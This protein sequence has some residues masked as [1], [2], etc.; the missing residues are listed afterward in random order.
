MN[1]KNAGMNMIVN[2]LE[3]CLA[4]FLILE[5]NSIY[6]AVLYSQFA[7][8]TRDVIIVITILLILLLSFMNRSR[9]NIDRLVSDTIIFAFLLVFVGAFYFINVR[10]L[11]SEPYYISAFLI[12]VPLIY[13][14]LKQIS[15]SGR[16]FSLFYCIS[17]IVFIIAIISLILW[18]S[19]SVFSIIRPSDSFVMSWAA[20]RSVSNYFNLF[21]TTS[22][23]MEHIG[24]LNIDLYRNVGIF[25]ESPM[26]NV[27]LIFSLFTELFLRVHTSKSKIA[28]LCMTI[29]STFGTIGIAIM[30]IG[31]VIKQLARL[32]KI[33]KKY[34]PLLIGGVLLLCIAGIVF[35]V[36]NKK[37]YGQSS[38]NTRL[39][40]YVAGYQTWLTAPFFGTGFYDT[41][42]IQKFMSEFRS[43][44]LGFS[45]SVVEVLANGGIYL[46]SF[47]MIP[48]I[49]FVM[50]VMKKGKRIFF[51]SIGIFLL[52]V[53]TIFEYHYLMLMVVAYGYSLIRL[54]IKLKG[55]HKHHW[56]KSSKDR[57]TDNNTVVYRKMFLIMTLISLLAT[58][59]AQLSIAACKVMGQRIGLKEIV[60]LGVAF[61]PYIFWGIVT[62]IRQRSE[63]KD[64]KLTNAFKITCIVCSIIQMVYIMANGFLLF[65]YSINNM[66]G[67]QIQDDYLQFV[68]AVIALIVLVIFLKDNHRCWGNLRGVKTGLCSFIVLCIL[69]ITCALWMRMQIKDDKDN[70]AAGL[71]M[72]KA[73]NI[74]K[75]DSV[76]VDDVPYIYQSLDKNAVYVYGT[77][78]REEEKNVIML[79]NEKPYQPVVD[80]YYK[81]YEYKDKHYMYFKGESYEEKFQDLGIAY[82]DHYDGE[83]NLKLE[84]IIEFNRQLTLDKEGVHLN[85]KGDSINY[86]PYISWYG[87]PLQVDL[88]L[89]LE[90]SPGNDQPIA[91][92]VLAYSKRQI[93][94]AQKNLYASDFDAEG[95]ATVS[96]S[97]F[98]K[99]TNDMEVLV[100]AEDGTKMNL[101]GI[102]YRRIE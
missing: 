82:L 70:I 81:C 24:F 68:I 18:M 73:L 57:K 69:N 16:P 102:C 86:G 54:P 55:G 89:K 100:V 90:E 99:W 50:K 2:I 20:K 30:L 91:H 28:L 52:F 63:Q 26:F 61:I 23:Q 29:L 31:L 92:L 22:Y 58:A 9:I 97:G 45:N 19:T 65:L 79:A 51:W 27:F 15:I 71:N 12:Y 5:G 78:D 41:A 53:T 95:N 76:Y 94:A 87:S 74:E 60:M 37:L 11:D 83:I 98:V 47:Y 42:S 62:I 43:D 8:V 13:L 67:I 40:D 80:G 59:M 35:L 101:K 48:F 56:E 10:G 39:D 75:T 17:D 66:L 64:S 34:Y 25:T 44:N 85:G 3:Y 72:L 77:P 36:M 32:V 4:L 6:S 96:L 33:N 14:L 46:F 21:F 7:D 38:Y 88:N 1:Q 84:N 93:V 49:M